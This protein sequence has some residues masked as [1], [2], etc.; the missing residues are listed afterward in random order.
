MAKTNI[1]LSDES[2]KVITRMAYLAKNGSKSKK[3]TPL[4]DEIVNTLIMIAG[5]AHEFL[6]A[7][8]F[9]NITLLE[10]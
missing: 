2:E 8:S 3:N 9:Y 10:K 5:K 7:E 6:D 4:K 1:V